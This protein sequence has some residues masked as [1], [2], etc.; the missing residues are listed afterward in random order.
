MSNIQS[1]QATTVTMRSASVVPASGL[2]MGDVCLKPAFGT[3]T[4]PAKRRHADAFQATAV[5]GPQPW[6]PPV[7]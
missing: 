3:A 5:A 1:W 7:T 2:V 4:A 6:S